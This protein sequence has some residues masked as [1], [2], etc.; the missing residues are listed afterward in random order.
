[1]PETVVIPKNEQNSAQPQNVSNGPSFIKGGHLWFE[2]FHD[3][4][5]TSYSNMVNSPMYLTLYTLAVITM[6]ARLAGV[7]T[8]AHSLMEQ[9]L[10]TYKSS[11]GPV[12]IISRA[13][14]L[15]FKILSTY[16]KLFMNASFIWV[17][18]LYKPSGKNM[19][20]SMFLTL[21]AVIFSSLNEFYLFLGSQLWFLFT[22]LRAPQHKMILV[23]CVIVLLT[24]MYAGTMD[25][26]TPT[27][28][29]TSTAETP[30]TTTYKPPQK[31]A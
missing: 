25:V 6:V 27:S 31:R 18:Y 10:E 3:A 20:F 29:P 11:T 28:S 12:Q 17:V 19:Y 13:A 14:Y 30:T 21:I 5:V 8:P 26:P 7:S 1:M 23:T 15:V 16:D 4:V 24:A 22:Q 2:G 9:A